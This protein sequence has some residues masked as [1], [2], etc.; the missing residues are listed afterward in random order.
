MS[1]K[2]HKKL[3]KLVSIRLSDTLVTAKQE[4]HSI[5]ADNY[6]YKFKSLIKAAI[7]NMQTN[8]ENGIKRV[9][10]MVW[11]PIIA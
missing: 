7:A 1:L 2:K 3:K 11:G 8:E 6:Y 10:L 4:V 5:R 9:C